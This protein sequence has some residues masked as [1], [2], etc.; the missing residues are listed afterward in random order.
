MEAQKRMK[1]KIQAEELSGFCAQLAMMLNSGMALYDGMEYLVQTHRSSPNAG[2]YEA[3]RQAVIQHGSLYAA[4]KEEESWPYYLVEM[5][6]IGERTGRLEEVLNGL[7][8]YYGREDRI[9]RAVINAVTYPLVL[10]VMMLLIMLIMIIKVLPV[11]QRVLGNFGVDMTDSG[12]A[13]MRLGVGIGWVMLIAVAVVVLVTLVCCLLIKIGYRNQ[14]LRVLRKVFPPLRHIGARIASARIASVLSMMISS[15]FPLDEALEMVARVIDDEMAQQQIARVRERVAQETSFEDAL[16][17]AGL[18]DEFY[19]G[20]IRMSCVAGC[21]DV[22]MAKVAA[23]YENRVEND[24]NNLVSI[25]E[26]SLVAVLS[27]VIGAV[28]LSVM[29]PMAGIIS[30]IL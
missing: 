9:R 27:I 6:G 30:S 5:V 15:G 10:G 25:I 17:E 23:E 11:F 2:A 20:L 24:I 13:M 4:M 14:V 16:S 26:P 21:V 12:N 28:L 22:T 18:F 7:S 3:L 19:T 1:W 8:E 29:L